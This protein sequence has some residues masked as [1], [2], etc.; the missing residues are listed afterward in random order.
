MN[1]A[2]NRKKNRTYEKLFRKNIKLYRDRKVTLPF[3]EVWVGKACSLRCKACIHMIPYIEPQTIDI[4]ELIR[5]CGKMLKL[6]T[7]E[8]LSVAGG[9][10]FCC[11]NLYKFLDYIK[12]E[13]AITNGKIITNGTVLPDE[14]TRNSIRN[15]NGKLEIRV[16][17]YPGQ[18][19]KCAPM[20]EFLEKDNIRHHIQWYRADKK[21]NWKFTGS[22]EQWEISEMMTRIIYRDCIDKHCYSMCGN[23]FTS[24]P[25]GI[26]SEEIFHVKKNPFEHIRVSE[27][28]E[29]ALSRA[30][31]ATC[32]DDSVY[33]NFCRYC[34]GLTEANPYYVVPGEQMEREY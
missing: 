1:E 3:L 20:V 34:L 8:Y 28:K 2:E 7:I 11:R 10:P 33:K 22:P 5:N 25:R 4:D 31:I 29:D 16:D 13:G 6:C 26:V 19:E 9:E 14:R 18:E 23:E 27:L 30:K 17:I 12:D 15:L 32:M 21:S 24:C